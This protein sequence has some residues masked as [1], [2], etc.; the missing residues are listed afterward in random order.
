MGIGPSS[1]LNMAQELKI[2]ISNLKQTEEFL[3]G[4][5]AQF[6]EEL[7]VK[8]TYFKQPDG[9]VLKISEDNRA[10]FIV[11]IDN[12]GE[13]F[14]IVSKNKIED[15][16]QTKRELTKKYE[17]KCVLNK[18]RRLFRWD[19]YIIDLNLI[20]NVGDFL[21]LQGENLSKDIITERLKIKD[22][23]FIHVSFDELN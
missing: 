8:D 18:K 2:K 20:D 22:P 3:R 23:E 17:I 14:K 21:V 6:I 4:K 12:E 7:T 19:N 5:G 13:T 15:I 1:L 16:S 10:D 11:K 9:K